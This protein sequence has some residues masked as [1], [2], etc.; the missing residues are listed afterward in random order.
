[1]NARQ[2]DRCPLPFGSVDGPSDDAWVGR[3]HVPSQEE[4]EEQDHPRMLRGRPPTP[5]ELPARNGIYI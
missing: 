5:T 1:M 3:T 4:A 2:S